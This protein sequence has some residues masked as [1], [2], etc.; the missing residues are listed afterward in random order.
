MSW[1]QWSLKEWNEALVRAVFFAH[2]RAET[3][4]SRI[5]ASGRFLVKCTNDRDSNPDEAL[6]LF[7]DAFGKTAA[8]VRSKFRVIAAADPEAM[9]SCFAA[10]YL[11]LLASSAD[12]ETAGVGD[13]RERFSK[14]VKATNG[15]SI[16]FGNLPLM[17]LH[18]KNWS[19]SRAQLFGDCALLVLPDPKNETLIGYSKRIAF[20]AYRDEQF[21][22]KTLK[23]YSLSESSSFADVARAVAREIGSAKTL[24]NF[25]EEF[26]EFQKLTSRFESQ[27]AYDSPFWGAVRDICLEE[28]QDQVRKKG[29]AC[30]AIDIA[31]PTEPLL[32]F[33]LDEIAVQKFGIPTKELDSARRDGCRYIAVDNGEWPSAN[34]L[35]AWVSKRKSISESKIGKGLSEGWLIFLPDQLGELTSEGSFYDGGPVCLVAKSMALNPLITLN[36]HYGVKSLKLSEKGAL[37]GWMGIYIPSV[38][39][40]YLKRLLSY[41]PVSV[42]AM[43]RTGWAPPRPRVSGG[44]WFGQMLLLNPSSNPIIR[45]RGA[46]TGEYRLLGSNHAEIKKGYL[47]EHEGGFQIPSI[48]LLVVESSAQACEFMLTTSEQKTFTAKIFITTETPEGLPARFGDRSQLLVDG[49]TG[50]LFRVEGGQESADAKALHPNQYP[51]PLNKFPPSLGSDTEFTISE[52]TNSDITEMSMALSW[53]TDSL[54]LRF[55]RRSSLTFELLREHI[56][57]AAEAS[58]IGA[59]RLQNLLFYGQW[60]VVH[61]QRNAPF[62][63]ISRAEIE[64]FVTRRDGQLIARVVGM[65]SKQTSARLAKLLQPGESIW[66]IGATNALCLGSIEIKL[67]SEARAAELAHEIGARLVESFPRTIPLAAL[68]PS[69]SEMHTVDSPTFSNQSEKWNWGWS[70]ASNEQDAWPVGELRRTI[71]GPK[72]WHWIK[73]SEKMFVKTDSAPWAWMVSSLARGDDMAEK[74]PEGSIVWSKSIIELPASLTRWWMLFG[75]GCIAIKDNGQV[76]FTGYGCVHA[77]NCMGWKS[78]RPQQELFSIALDRR[79][80]A[81]RLKKSRRTFDL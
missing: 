49:P 37:D 27:Q 47:V 18:V 78:E 48:D 24:P 73:L 46:L 31:D 74:T 4:V 39:E 20:P 77:I 26:R 62:R 72:A 52:C 22:R 3:T 41:V 38:S 12:N 70:P 30:L 45:M 63:C 2:G 7:I 43:L 9:P 57:G 32:H 6:Q 35:R 5:D 71:N 14:I 56:W 64:M 69:T 75:G 81:M 76:L 44:A 67:L 68:H 8:A 17:W 60:L 11:T 50:M 65:L 53:I 42:Q 55:E 25:L 15:H 33:Y 13:F 58:G 34:E 28:T 29:I 66:R 36:E 21:L 19:I 54:T 79:R 10:L 40:E 80:L 51:L 61:T 1:K 23:K 16:D 59:R